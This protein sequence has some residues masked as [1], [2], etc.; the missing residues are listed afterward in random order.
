MIGS[1]RI[2]VCG[3]TGVADIAVARSLGVDFFGINCWEGSPRFVPAARRAILLREIP[4]NARIAITVN[5]T[6]EQALALRTEGFDIIQVHF[7]PDEAKTDP[8]ALSKALQPQ[9]LWLAP[10]IAPGKTFPEAFIPLADGLL[11]DAYQPNAFGGTGQRADWT[12]F[13]QTAQKHPSKLWILAGGL[14]RT[15][16]VDASLTGAGCLDLNSGVEI[17]PGLK[18][19]QLLTLTLQALLKNKQI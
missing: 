6:V 11:Q 5:P 14:K 17:G 3:L 1:L 18:S 16:V 9:H 12:A 15:N 7:N 13:T 10:K 2:K 4:A 8:V 19:A